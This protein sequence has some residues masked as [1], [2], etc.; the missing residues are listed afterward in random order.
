MMVAVRIKGNLY[1]R[2][3]LSQV[4]RPRRYPPK[5][6]WY[7]SS[8]MQYDSSDLQAISLGWWDCF[9]KG[10]SE[11]RTIKAVTFNWYRNIVRER[12]TLMVKNFLRDPTARCLE[13]LWELGV[14]QYLY[15]ITISPQLIPFF[16]PWCQVTAYEAEVCL[17]YRHAHWY[18]TLWKKK[19]KK[20]HIEM[21]NVH[22]LEN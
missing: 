4:G 16:L 2:P 1:Y 15:D 9:I 12:G 22:N 6:F 17:M 21:K 10:M 3:D 19:I 13:D 8:S 5:A 7:L 18:T 11:I 14:L 20:E